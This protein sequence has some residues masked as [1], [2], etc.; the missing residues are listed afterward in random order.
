M[1]LLTRLYTQ[2]HF[3]ERLCARPLLRLKLIF[4]RPTVLLSPSVLALKRLRS[5]VTAAFSLS[6]PARLYSVCTCELFVLVL[7]PCDGCGCFPAAAM[8]H[9]C[10]P[11][12]CFCQL[13]LRLTHVAFFFFCSGLK[14]LDKSRPGQ[15]NWDGLHFLLL[16]AFQKQRPPRE[17]AGKPTK[18][19]IEKTA[20][21]KSQFLSSFLFCQ[22]L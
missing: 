20:C 17:P 9:I 8:M 15:K 12:R 22:H 14:A 2:R 4:S 18:K 3:T 6:S 7:S 10:D 11:G 5:C 19:G 16:N 13:L 1:Y 21:V